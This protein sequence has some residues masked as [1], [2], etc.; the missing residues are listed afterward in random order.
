[1]D[2]HDGADVL[3]QE[4]WGYYRE[5]RCHPVRMVGIT[6]ATMNGKGSLLHFIFGTRCG[7]IHRLF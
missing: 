1:M 6:V 7:C 5:R 2:G 4:A 3:V